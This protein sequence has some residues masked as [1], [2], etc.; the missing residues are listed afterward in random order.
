MTKIIKSKSPKEAKREVVF[1]TAADVFA[2]YG[3]RRTAMNDIAK[4]AGISRPALYLMFENKEDLFRGV[5]LFRQSQGIDKA[6]LILAGTGSIAERFNTS[7]IAFEKVFY[8]PV[9]QSPHGAELMDASISIAAD[10]MKKG[11]DRLEKSLA[12][13]LEEA[14]SSKEVE[15]TGMSMTPLAFTCLLMSSI[16]GLKKHA[17]STKGLRRQISEVTGIFFKA[18]HGVS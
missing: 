1:E 5:V 17:T 15:F 4:A 6:I 8:E 14:I 12:R 10:L 7:I 16:S 2:Q 11:Q 9:A 13:A 3:F 18:I